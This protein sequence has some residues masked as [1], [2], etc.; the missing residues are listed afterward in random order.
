MEVGYVHKGVFEMKPTNGWR[1]FAFPFI[2]A[3]VLVL[4]MP[5]VAI[6]RLDP[7]DGSGVPTAVYAPY[8]VVDG[9]ADA[10][11]RWDAY[12]VGSAP[13][14]PYTVEEEPYAPYEAGPVV[15]ESE[16]YAPYEAGPVIH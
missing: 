2:A 16:A 4:A 5:S 13:Y 1:R 14:A 7:L 10:L 9:S 12:D 11:A 3:L 15:P 6:A 8:T